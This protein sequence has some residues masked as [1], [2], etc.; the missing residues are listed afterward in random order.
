MLMLKVTAAAQLAQLQA[1]FARTK[2]SLNHDIDL[3][4]F[5]LSGNFDAKD[6]KVP[7]V[8]V[9]WYAKGGFTD[10]L[11][12]AGEDG[13]EAVLSFNPAYR[14]QNLS[15]WAKA[16]QLLGVDSKLID[17]ITGG[18]STSQMTEISL[19]G[20]SF[21]PSITINGNA[22]KEDVIA[23]IREEEPEFFDLLDRYLAA[24]GRESYGF[25]Y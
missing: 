4:H 14:S 23:A 24:K 10:G 9:K 13:M 8:G 15:Y 25:S 3:P 5:T 21:N 19:G 17:L 2:F 18:A 16:G 1:L 11:S 6:G 7:N 20:V 22:T 12:I